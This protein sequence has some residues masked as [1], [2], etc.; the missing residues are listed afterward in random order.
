ME[1]FIEY[2]S[3]LDPDRCEHSS[4]LLVFQELYLKTSYLNLNN[5]LE[6]KKFVAQLRLLNRYNQRIIYRGKTYVLNSNLT[7]HFCNFDQLDILHFIFNC[8]VFNNL[9]S[10]FQLGILNT[11]TNNKIC[12]FFDSLNES[13]LDHLIK[14][15]LCLLNTHLVDY[16]RVIEF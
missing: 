16:I 1:K 11:N 2:R 12:L 15:T 4:S 3:N 5:R 14:F 6:C 8:P 7:C 10:S 13:S 9:R